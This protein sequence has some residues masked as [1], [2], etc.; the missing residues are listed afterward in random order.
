VPD[1]SSYKRRKPITLKDASKLA[2]RDFRNWSEVDPPRAFSRDPG[3]PFWLDPW[4]REWEMF[5]RHLVHLHYDELSQWLIDVGV[6]RD[7]IWSAQGFMA[8]AGDAMPFALAIDSPVKNYDSGGMSVE[9]AKPKYG[10][11]GAILYGAAA[12]NDTPME[13]NR[14]LFATLASIDPGFG[15]V[16]FNTADLRAPEV[17]PTYAAAYRSLRDLWNAGARFISPMAWNGSNGAFLGKPGYVT[18]TAWRNTPL[19]DAAYDFLLARADLPLGDKLWTFGT[20]RH[21]DD[22]GWTAEIGSIALGRGTLRLTTDGDGRIALVSPRSLGLTPERMGG[23]VAGLPSDAAIRGID[24][25]ARS[26]P[27]GGWR[28]LTT[29]RGPAIVTTA[30]GRRVTQHAQTAAS[31]DQLKIEIEFDKPMSDVPLTH[32]AVVSER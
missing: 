9:G 16:E 15:V 8:P 28:L 30:A 23:I 6:P 13:N 20:P 10:H 29:A 3:H 17:P 32:I 1:L 24:F 5:R 31:I 26:Q 18:F 12:V 7:R 2:K 19:E 25:Y 4:V 22:D 11:L 21:A 14:S 27:G